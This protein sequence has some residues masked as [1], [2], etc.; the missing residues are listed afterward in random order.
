MASI[1]GVD[2]GNDLVG[3]SGDGNPSIRVR[4]LAGICGGHTA[5]SFYSAD[6]DLPALARRFFYAV[7]GRIGTLYQPCALDSAGIGLHTRRS[8]SCRSTTSF[9]AAFRSGIT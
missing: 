5:I 8:F 4:S 9:G 7:R 6:E 3:C 2:C 1:W